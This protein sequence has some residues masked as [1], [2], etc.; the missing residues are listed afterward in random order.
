MAPKKHIAFVCP[1]FAE[2]ATIGG[3]ETL[4]RKLAEH[5]AAHG[6]QVTFLTTCA[7]NH[8]TWENK[9]PAGH[10]QVGDIHLIRFPVDE[11]RDV[12]VFLR[13]QNA[14]SNDGQFTEA[15]ERNWMAN[16]VN[17]QALYQ[18]LKEE[19][20]TY[21][22][23]LAGPYMFGIT[24]HV[25]QIHPEKT[26]LIPCL[27]DEPFAYLTIM[28]DLFD[29]VAGFLFNAV[30]EQHLAQK[31]FSIE[32]DRCSVVGMGMDAFDVDPTAFARNHNI[33]VPYILYSGRREPMKGTPLLLDYLYAFR[34]RT[35]IDVKLVLT[36]SGPV[37]PPDALWP[38][39]LDV[40]IVSEQEKQE[41][42]AGATVFCHPSTNESFGI[43]LLEAWLAGT[44]ALVHAHGE[45]LSYHCRK[46]GGGLW[47]R[48]YPDFEEELKLL[49]E[50]QPLRDQLAQAGQQYVQDMYAWENVEKRLMAG[51]ERV[52]NQP[53]VNIE[54][55]DK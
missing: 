10:T 28:H 22:C 13:I 6:Y 50:N 54:Q 45:V 51:I 55:R 36:G 32:P 18:H 29:A 47:F 21:D 27:H 34:E 38:H 40:G 35:K 25:G 42:M 2:G 23:I 46:S 7:E 14:I 5:T 16:S 41:A 19:G 33:A 30:P 44:P 48:S 26:L 20:D 52:C 1:R 24:W 39:I 8:F 9:W 17:S 37:E 31:I 49:L 11:D 43:V 15:D 3:A 4:L 53:A 12:G